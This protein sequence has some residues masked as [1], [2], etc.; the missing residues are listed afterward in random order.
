MFRPML[1]IVPT[2]TLLITEGVNAQVT[3]P[4]RGPRLRAIVPVPDTSPHD[5]LRTHTRQLQRPPR[6]L[7]FSRELTDRFINA[8]PQRCRVQSAHIDERIDPLHLRVS[9]PAEQ[10]FALGE[11]Q[12]RDNVPNCAGTSTLNAPACIG[13]IVRDVVRQHSNILPP[14]TSVEFAALASTDRVAIRSDGVDSPHYYPSADMDT[15]AAHAAD[16]GPLDLNQ[17]RAEAS[18]SPLTPLQERANACLS[19]RRAWGAVRAFAGGLTDSPMGSIRLEAYAI[20]LGVQRF[21][22]A[23]DL[24]PQTDCPIVR[25]VTFH[26]RIVV[27]PASQP[28]ECHPSDNSAMAALFCEQR[29]HRQRAFL[30]R[31]HSS[32][33]GTIPLRTSSPHSPLPYCVG[34]DSDVRCTRLNNSIIE[35]TIQ[36]F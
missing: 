29:A 22:A 18:I 21:D 20:G 32:Q 19:L 7:D 34:P 13:R 23:G 6:L 31:S 36:Q 2:V 9:C 35:S 15:D 1:Y 25:A 26:V 11:W 30:T 24:C 10:L 8:L 3:D 12:L 28:D 5:D 17:L 16:C 27:P 33:P 4:N 14:G